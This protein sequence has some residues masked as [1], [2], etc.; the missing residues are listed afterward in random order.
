[1]Y[2]AK[3]YISWT[4][5]RIEIAKKLTTSGSTAKEVSELTGVSLRSA[6]NF[7]HKYHENGDFKVGKPG[8][9]KDLTTV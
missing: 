3:K 7:I 6:Q 8:Q 2:S 1:M 5:E 4:D 9:K